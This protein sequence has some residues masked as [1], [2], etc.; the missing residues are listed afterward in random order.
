MKK[1]TLESQQSD[2][3]ASFFPSFLFS[4]SHKMLKVP[5]TCVEYEAKYSY[6]NKELTL[7]RTIWDDN[8]RKGATYDGEEKDDVTAKGRIERCYNRCKQ[9]QNTINKCD[10]CFIEEN[11]ILGFEN[12]VAWKLFYDHATFDEI[13]TPTAR[14][15]FDKPRYDLRETVETLPNYPCT[16][17]FMSDDKACKLKT[18]PEEIMTT[19]ISKCTHYYNYCKKWL[20]STRDNQDYFIHRLKKESGFDEA[21]TIFMRVLHAA[22][23]HIDKK[24][25]E[26]AKNLLLDHLIPLHVDHK[27]GL[28]PHYKILI[29]MREIIYKLAS[30]LSK[31]CKYEYLQGED[32]HDPDTMKYLISWAEENDL[33]IFNIASASKENIVQLIRTPADFANNFMAKHYN[34]S[35]RTLK[36]SLKKSTANLTRLY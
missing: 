8:R 34:I 13:M 19:P 16:G 18:C 25:R 33:R 24:E 23:W 28:L 9:P 10:A 1:K 26:T 22:R 15:I 14:T 4:F 17:S 20:Q 36:M 30:N 21:M 7:C 5:S 32:L 6:W 35:I 3:K 31:K 11:S 12:D 2:L 29:P 27:T